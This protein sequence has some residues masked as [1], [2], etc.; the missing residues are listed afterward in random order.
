M[1][2]R[3]I[4]SL[5]LA[6]LIGGGC[7]GGVK[8]LLPLERGQAQT[9]QGVDLVAGDPGGPIPS[10]A[11]PP[12]PEP[13]PGRGRPDTSEGKQKALSYRVE[14]QAPQAE[15]L[16]RIFEQT[17]RLPLMIDT[18]VYTLVALEQRLNVSLKEGRDIL[19]SRG[20]YG[21][22]VS[23]RVE[24]AENGQPAAV[25]VS[26]EPGPRYLLG[27]NQVLNQADIL[28]PEVAALPNQDHLPRTLAD[29][30]LPKG[31]P[32]LADDVLEAVDRMA[33]AFQN[34]GYP[35]ARIA[36][37]RYTVDH[38]TRVLEAEI[39]VEPGAYALMGPVVIE[40]RSP[41][42]PAYLEIQRYWR[43]GQ[44]WDQRRVEA[45]RES[46]LQSGLFKQIELNPAPADD[47]EGRRAVV[48]TLDGAPA[49]TVGGALKYDSNFGLGLQ[50]HWE[51]RNLTGWGDKLSLDLPIWQDLQ[52]FTATYRRPYFLRRNQDFLF[53]GG[54]LHEKADSYKLM[55]G[56]VSSGVERRLARYWRGS[57]SGS[58]EAGSLEE[59]NE[60]RARRN[61]YLLGMPGQ[62]IY[63]RTNSL[64][65]AT[66]GARLT[67][68]ASPYTGRY[69]KDFNVIRTR[70]E[71][72][73]FQ[74]FNEKESFVLAAR[75]VWGALWDVS[76]QTV[77]TSIRF[78]SGGGGSVRGYEYQSVGPRNERKEPLGGSSLLETGVEGRFRFS[79]T[80]GLAAFV[81]G[82]MVYD[83]ALV[84]MKQNMLWGAGLG[85]RY[86]TAIGPLRLDLATPLNPRDDDAPVQIYISIGQS[87]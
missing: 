77:P 6:L 24:Q 72:Q 79:E 48:A 30:G 13:V 51:H 14:C 54:L 18:P 19:N 5:I 86:F 42:K 8:K 57:L 27:P 41:V 87:F 84:E 69:F 44:P 61:Y 59:T 1:P 2:V 20:Y 65:D 17:A 63:D 29:V 71:A 47:S 3:F 56:A 58:F 35:W 10:P 50:A 85:L 25:A 26:F 76:A 39:K 22:D 7:S 43:L 53:Q 15:E 75:G 21:G 67:V 55:S 34:N 9:R 73:V 49:R 60:A 28:N 31:S 23:G 45:L 81:D 82:G 46:L 83:Q 70:V 80:L 52:Q 66:R 62:L 74:P 33:E 78:Y 64:L 12:D 40:G 11:L 38:E 16:C 68:L 36:G 32:A 4:I 37:A